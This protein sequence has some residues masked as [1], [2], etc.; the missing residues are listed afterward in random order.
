MH[1]ASCGTT[2]TGRGRLFNFLLGDPDILDS[3]RFQNIAHPVSD[4]TPAYRILLLGLD[5]LSPELLSTGP[6][7][8]G[9]VLGLKTAAPRIIKIGI[10]NIGGAGLLDLVTRPVT[11]KWVWISNLGEAATYH[12]SRHAEAT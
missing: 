1:L 3:E 11:P 10:R 5:I 7:G 4:G 6:V 2:C 9:R 12:G 8:V